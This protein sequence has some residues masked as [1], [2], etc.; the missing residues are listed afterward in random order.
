MK[1]HKVKK[2]YIN[3][4]GYNINFIKKFNMI[5]SIKI[6]Y[7]LFNNIDYSI[8]FKSSDICL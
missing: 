3:N 5:K 1:F 2:I 8:D 4:I 6:Y 7:Y